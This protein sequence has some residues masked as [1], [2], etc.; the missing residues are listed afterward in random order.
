MDHGEEGDLE[1]KVDDL[2]ADLED[3]RS[4]FEKLLADE[5]GKDDDDMDEPM[6][7]P[8]PEEE[9]FESVEYD[10]DEEIADESDE[11][12]EEA[13]KLQDAVADPKGGEADN[14]ESPMTK[15]P[16]KTK[17]AGAGQ[18]V[19]AKDGSDGNSGDNSPKDTGASDNLK[20]EPKKV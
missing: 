19:K 8:E 1:D 20:V 7:M 5:D 4:E 10:L 18:P 15:A 11:V 3:L 12:V 13:T 6:D 9:E 16:A 17:V 14:S 2:E